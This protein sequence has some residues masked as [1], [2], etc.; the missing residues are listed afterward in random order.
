[1][2]KN[3]SL[4]SVFAKQSLAE[5]FRARSLR[6]ECDEREPEQPGPGGGGLGHRGHRHGGEHRGGGGGGDPQP[7]QPPVCG[8]P[9]ICEY[10][11]LVN[12]ELRECI[13]R[14]LHSP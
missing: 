5:L 11:F 13:L 8:V 14:C 1:M 6:S 10:N 7:S 2:T 12:I 3:V 9:Q 4:L